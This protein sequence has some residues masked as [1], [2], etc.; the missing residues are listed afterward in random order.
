MNL[1]T[2][3]E[4][5]AKKPTSDYVRLSSTEGIKIHYTGGKVPADLADSGNHDRCVDL[6]QD[7]Q[8]MHMSG[9]AARSTSTWATTWCAALTGA[10]SW[11]AAPTHSRPPTARAS[12][13][14][15]TRCSPWSAARA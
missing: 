14:A 15:T 10:R 3:A 8:R 2:R 7:I 5:H 4:W 1:V 12:T 13:P 9:A 6:V 11:A